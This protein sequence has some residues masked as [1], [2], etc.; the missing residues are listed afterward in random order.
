MRAAVKRFFEKELYVKHSSNNSSAVGTTP[1]IVVD[2]EIDEL[3]Q[4]INDIYDL[5]Q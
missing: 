3:I 5:N 2:H 1:N 4:M